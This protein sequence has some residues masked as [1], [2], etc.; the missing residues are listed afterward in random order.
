M[1]GGVAYKIKNISL[2]E[3][4]KT[5][6]GEKL[7]KIN[8]EGKAQSFFWDKEAVLPVNKKNGISLLP[9]GNKNPNI[10]L[11]KTGWA[12]LES[13]EAH[14]WDYLEPEFVDIPVFLGFEKNVWFDLKGAKGVVV[15]KGN[16]ERVYMIT[17]EASEE[18]KKLTKHD[19]EPLRI[20]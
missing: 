14:K 4:E 18:H 7:E 11:P 1:C 20:K 17:K 9:W 5:F 12:R 8:K 15:R 3:L 6:N 10:S 13:L 2:V 16:I 19:R